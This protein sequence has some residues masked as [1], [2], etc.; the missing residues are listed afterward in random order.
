MEIDDI[1]NFLVETFNE[2]ERYED[3]VL[4]KIHKQNLSIKEIHVLEQVI[5]LLKVNKNTLTNVS[6]NL[7]LSLGT[8][9]ISI[10]TLVKKG[11]LIKQ[12]EQKDKRIT[13]LIPTK[14][15][16]DVYE[17]HSIFHKKMID[18]ISSITSTSEREL[19]AKVLNKIMFYFRNKAVLLN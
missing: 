16:T 2:L 1:N 11:Y 3:V 5:N 18:E 12:K 6:K 8:I 13:Y 10:A 14:L 4:K 19:L 17:I 9:S 15:A 7:N